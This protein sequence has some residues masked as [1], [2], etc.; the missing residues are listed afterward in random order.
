MSQME[1]ANPDLLTDVVLDR[2]S[3]DE[4]INGLHNQVIWSAMGNFHKVHVID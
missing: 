3:V 1:A 4:H 2:M